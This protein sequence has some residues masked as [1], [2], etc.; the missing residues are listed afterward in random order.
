MKIGAKIAHLAMAAGMIRPTT[1]VTPTMAMSKGSEFMLACSTASA[2][3][4]G[5]IVARLL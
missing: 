3:L 2:R 5:A 1:M 4:I